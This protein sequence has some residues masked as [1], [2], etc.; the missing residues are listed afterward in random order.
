MMRVA[1]GVGVVVAAAVLVTGCSSSRPGASS[2]PTS[3]AVPTTEAGRPA[4]SAP[5]TTPPL[6]PTAYNCGAAAYEPAT[7]LIVCGVGTSMATG[8]KWSDWTSTSASGHGEVAVTGRPPH[9]ASLRLGSVVATGAG[10]QF[11]LL[12]V[13]WSGTSPDGHPADTFHLDTSPS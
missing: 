12:T 11:S 2:G 5:T 8:V 1:A 10:P 9:P 13:T 6:T 4:G 3:G 7:L